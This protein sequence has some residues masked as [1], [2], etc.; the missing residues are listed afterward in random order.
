MAKLPLIF[1]KRRLYA[2]QLRAVAERRF[3]DAECLLA[4]GDP[5]RANGAIYMAG[6]VIECLLKALLLE[7]HPNLSKPVDPAKLSDSDREIFG[8][9]YGHDLDEMLGALPELGTKLSVVSTP[10]GSRVWPEFRTLCEHW[11]VYARYSPVS[12]KM[13]EAKNF[14]NT[15]KEVK[16]WLKEL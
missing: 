13:T 2:G 14:L 9:L 1:A 16:K 12:A 4:S 8:Y 6:F 5:E 11:T 3:A 7:R 10:H 15:V